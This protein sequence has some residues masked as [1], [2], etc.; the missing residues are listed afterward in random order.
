[1]RNNKKVVLMSIFVLC[2]YAVMNMG[3]PVTPA[4]LDQRTID[5]RYFGILFAAMA[6]MMVL[7]APF[8][9]SKGDRFGRRKILA[10]GIAGYGL[11][12]MIFGLGQN[13]EMILFGRFFSGFFAASIFT[14]QI[15]SFSEISTEETRARNLSL[16]TG[17][18]ILGSSLGYF[19]GGKL[20][21]LFSPGNTIIIQGFIGFAISL[22]L[23]LF[24]PETNQDRGNIKK[25]RSFIQNLSS[26]REMDQH[27]LY[28][29]L[30][31]LFW[32]MAKNN[33]Q[34][35]LDVFLKN[36]GLSP[37]VIGTY[38]M[39]FGFAGGIAFILVP[40]LAKK[41]KLL[42]LMISTLVAMIVCLFFTFTMPDIHFALIT[43]FLGYTMLATVYTAVEQI[44]IS[45]NITENHGAVLGVR[46]S[47]RSIG[48]VL[49]PLVVTFLFKE[50]TTMVF[51]FNIGLFLIALGI[52]CF[53]TKKSKKVY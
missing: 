20:G 46:E 8:W 11:G 40:F 3:H 48:L 36:Q 38:N 41:M 14:N 30:S 9:G 34:K 37:D 53:F 45:K 42:Y 2:I 21:V 27:I 19:I 50:V 12:Q 32:S 6:L 26:L 31:V 47:F 1:M 13:I 16:I 33:V 44:Y 22:C 51:F 15:A 29:L 23:F 7:F 35:F 43:T 18:G 39:V 10:L 52:L 25:R 17:F 28:F 49:G 4:L 24:H 5:E